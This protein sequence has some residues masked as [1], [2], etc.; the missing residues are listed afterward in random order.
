ML[1]SNSFPGAPKAS[2]QTLVLSVLLYFKPLT[3]TTFL[4]KTIGGYSGCKMQL[5]ALPFFRLSDHESPFREDANMLI[6]EDECRMLA[7]M[8]GYW[9]NNPP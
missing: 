6:M 8:Q 1:I 4:E 5:F 2:V 9:R 7:D 3:G